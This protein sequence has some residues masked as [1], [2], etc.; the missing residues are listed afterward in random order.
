M[1]SPV[2]FPIAQ[3]GLR[4]W[5]VA[6]LVIIADQFTKYLV[7]SNMA[8]HEV[9]TLLPVLDLFRTFN[10]GA[11]WSMFDDAGGAQR[12]VFSGLAIVVSALLVFWLRKLAVATHAVLTM[13]IALILGGAIGNVIDRLRLGHVV[14]FIRVHWHESAFPTFN[15]ADSAI[16][17]GAALVLLDAFMESR[18]ER[19]AARAGH[20]S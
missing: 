2:T 17:V 11:A 7:V 12:W 4:L 5:W 8:M 9:I 15:L 19:A 18:R 14:D 10:L 13:G 16:S 6:L 3:S 1:N 20:G